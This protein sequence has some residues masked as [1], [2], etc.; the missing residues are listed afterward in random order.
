VAVPVV[1]GW[2]D[3]E[4]ASVGQAA[5]VEWVVVSGNGGGGELAGLQFTADS[6]CAAITV[7]LRVVDCPTIY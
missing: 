5:A 4:A 1:S 7:A 2:R 3:A 6:W